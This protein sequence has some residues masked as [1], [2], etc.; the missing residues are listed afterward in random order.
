MLN[1]I[2]CKPT[3]LIIKNDSEFFF[4]L[5]LKYNRQEMLLLKL[6]CKLDHM[7]KSTIRSFFKNKCE[8]ERQKE[9]EKG[10][11][12]AEDLADCGGERERGQRAS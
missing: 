10:E 6:R 9:L 5:I 12:E 11:G 1:I 7:P 8:T 4:S 2:I 3:K